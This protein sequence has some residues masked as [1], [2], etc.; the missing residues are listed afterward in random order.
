MTPDEF[1]NQ[2]LEESAKRMVKRMVSA[3][4]RLGIGVTGSLVASIK[5]YV[6]GQLLE[7]YFNTS[8]R[9]RDMGVGKGVTLSEVRA[10]NRK[11]A[12]FYSKPAYSEVGLLVYSLSSRFVNETLSEMQELDGLQI[13]L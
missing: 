8:G 13:K 1:M 11:P 9:F 4:Q 12:L 2:E 6:R 10:L 5:A 3:A 7:L